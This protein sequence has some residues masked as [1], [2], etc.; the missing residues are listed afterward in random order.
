MALLH[1]GEIGEGEN[2]VFLLK[3]N[4]AKYSH[5]GEIG[6]GES[7]VRLL[8]GMKNESVQN[9][10]VRYEGYNLIRVTTVERGDSSSDSTSL[11]LNIRQLL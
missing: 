3:R 8:S 11:F 7:D 6:E 5:T 2:D 9:Y 10:S 4:K 1:A